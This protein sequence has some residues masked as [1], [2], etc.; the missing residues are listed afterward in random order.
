M[1]MNDGDYM[2]SPLFVW[3]DPDPYYIAYSF[4]FSTTF[5]PAQWQQTPDYECYVIPVFDGPPLASPPPWC[6][7]DFNNDGIV[8]FKDF[9]VFAS[10]W[11]AERP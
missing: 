4:T 11:L 10:Y 6:P 5:G 2:V 8:D 3:Y 9:A 1:N 7:A